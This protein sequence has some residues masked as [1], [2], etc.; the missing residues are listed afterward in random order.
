[1]QRKKKYLVFSILTL[2]AILSSLFIILDWSGFIFNTYDINDPVSL[3]SSRIKLLVSFLCTLLV[4]II[5]RD[6]INKRDTRRLTF[7]FI[8]VFFADFN[9][10]IGNAVLGILTFGIVQ[11]LLI[12]R[13]GTGFKEFLINSKISDRLRFIIT[14]IFILIILGTLFRYILYPHINSK[15]ILYVLLTYQLLLGCSFFTAWASLKIRYF[16]TINALFAALGM[17]FFLLC[18]LTVGMNLLFSPS[19]YRTV[20][21]YLTWIFYT[22]ALILIGLSGYDINSHTTLK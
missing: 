5:G 2:I 20:A 18:D 13:N 7:I 3:N 21:S 16:P 8:L 1:M 19:I 12:L 9:F 10:F 22:P 4:C 17:T 15:P 11:T 6:G 14:G